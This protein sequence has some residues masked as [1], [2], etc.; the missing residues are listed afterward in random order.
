MSPLKGGGRRA[1]EPWAPAR[2]LRVHFLDACFPTS[3]NCCSSSKVGI[4]VEGGPSPR[5]SRFSEGSPPSLGQ[6][7][8]AGGGALQSRRFPI[9]GAPSR[10]QREVATR[11]GVFSTKSAPSPPARTG[12]CPGEH[13][14]EARPDPRALGL[15]AARLS[16]PPAA[17]PDAR[18]PEGG[19][20]WGG[21][22]SAGSLTSSSSGNRDGL[23]GPGRGEASS[24]SA[25]AAAACPPPPPPLRF[26]QTNK[27][28]AA[29]AAALPAAQT[30][31]S[32]RQ[33]V[34]GQNVPR[35]PAPPAEAYAGNCAGA[36]SLSS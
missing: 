9:P 17:G 20:N 8:G 1:L 16:L 22:G 30:L 32:N 31:R 36:C 6:A 24:S 2:A 3:T 11:G 13:G 25:A 14:E 33:D 12:A 34:Y 7:P 10:G 5:R 18:R 19:E 29:M 23:G 28:A 21:G 26:T 15:A 27:M 4:G 35:A